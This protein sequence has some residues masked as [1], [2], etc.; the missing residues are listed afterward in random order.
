MYVN[1]AKSGTFIPSQIHH[2]ITSLLGRLPICIH[3]HVI[4]TIGINEMHHK[5]PVYWLACG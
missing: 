3:N 2:S 5:D 4:P 1:Q